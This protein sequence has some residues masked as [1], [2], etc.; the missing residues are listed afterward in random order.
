MQLNLHENDEANDSLSQSSDFSP[1]SSPSS[2]TTHAMKVISRRKRTV[3]ESEKI[4]A[5]PTYYGQMIE[6]CRQKGHGFVRPADGGEPLFVHISDIDGD[7]VPREGDEVSYKLCP[8]PPKNLRFAAV[9][10]QIVLLKSGVQH[11]TWDKSGRKLDLPA[12]HS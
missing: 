7:L 6:F 9:H 10:V 8:I 4:L 12:S 3:S 1:P 2:P 11:E 5:G